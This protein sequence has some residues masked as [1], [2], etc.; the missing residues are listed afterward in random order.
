MFNQLLSVKER[1]LDHRPI[2]IF[3]AGRF[4][5]DL[6][7]ILKNSGFNVLGFVESNARKDKVLGLPVLNINQVG[8]D[9]SNMQL[10][11]GIFSREMPF[12]NIEAQA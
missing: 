2:W 4:G 1:T 12:D 3:G 7:T 6:C 5:R 8:T 10:A 11:V 9:N